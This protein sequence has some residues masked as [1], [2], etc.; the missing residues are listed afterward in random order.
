MWTGIR[1]LSQPNRASSSYKGHKGSVVLIKEQYMCQSK[2]AE[3]SGSSSISTTDIE[4]LEDSSCPTEG[5][6]VRTI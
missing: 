5:E 4:V 2:M 6:S 3:S 1:E